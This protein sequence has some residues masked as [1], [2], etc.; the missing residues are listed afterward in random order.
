MNPNKHSLTSSIVEIRRMK[1]IRI[2]SCLAGLT[3]AMNAGAATLVYDSFLTGT[4]NYSTTS[5]PLVSSGVG[6][7]SSGSIGFTGSWAG[8][9]SSALSST[10]TNLPMSGLADNKGGAMY[11]AP[12]SN[13][14]S[15]RSDS[16]A[17]TSLNKGGVLWFSSILK[18]DANTLSSGATAMT[19]FL[20]G[21]L[22]S[23]STSNSAG[24]AT[25]NG[26]SLGGFAWGMS[27]GH[28]S[29]S[30]QSNA[31]GAGAVTTTST[32]FT[33]VANNLYFLVAQLDTSVNASDT[34]KL[35]ALTSVPASSA[36]LGTPTW[37]ISTADILNGS[38]NTFV[39]YSAV[40]GVA[41]PVASTTSFDAITVA[42]SYSDLVTVNAVPEPATSAMLIFGTVMTA[43][44]L[45]KR[46]K[47]TRI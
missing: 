7:T 10:P 13:V 24:W 3:L 38:L 11:V 6:Q 37:S 30:Y 20:T 25:S 15:T 1:F 9:N 46:R 19:G 47:Q 21:S 34:L 40:N 18:T 14:T 42:T 43:G 36:L 41:S 28:L 22:P 26:A 29:V 2:T 44:W 4:G 8:A 27:G 32:G 5:A 16:R 23:T 33:P 45:G 35:W 31:S 17:F 39:A 12:Y